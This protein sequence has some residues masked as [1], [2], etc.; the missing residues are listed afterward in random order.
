VAGL[1]VT[2]ERGVE[3]TALTQADDA[4]RLTLRLIAQ[5]HDPVGR[6]LETG[7]SDRRQRYWSSWILTRKGRGARCEV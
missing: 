7:N 6:P 4:A 2:V 5:V 3:L 1:G